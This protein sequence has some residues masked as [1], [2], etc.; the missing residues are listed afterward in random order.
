MINMLHYK[1]EIKELKEEISEAAD[2]LINQT[3]NFSDRVD[4]LEAALK[5]ADVFNANT[6]SIEKLRDN[7]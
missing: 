4:L 1:V 2:H 7:V 6:K 5:Y 3:H